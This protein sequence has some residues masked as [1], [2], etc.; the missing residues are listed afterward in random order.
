VLPYLG[1]W[2]ERLVRHTVGPCEVRVVAPVPYCPPLPA[3]PDYTRFRQVPAFR[4]DGDVAVYHPRFLLGPGNW[5]HGLEAWGYYHGVRRLVGRIRREFPFDLIHAHFGY[6]DGVVAAWLGQRY[7]VPVVVTEHAIWRPWLDNFRSVRQKVLQ[8]AARFALHLAVSRAVRDSVAHFTGESEHLRVIPVGVDA[9]V[10]TPPDGGAERDPNQ[11]LFVGR[12]QT[13]KGVDILLRAVARLAGLRPGLQLTIVGGS[14]YPNWR[15]EEER[16]RRLAQELGLGPRVAFVGIQPE[17]QV[18]QLMRRSAVVVLPS[19]RE[20][21]GAVLV[22]ALACGTPVVAT[23]CGGPEDVVTD[24]VGRLVPLE[25]PEALASAIDDV[26]GAAGR[27]DARA[28]RAYAL[29]HFSWERVAGRTVGS[30]QEAC[31]QPARSEQMEV[32]PC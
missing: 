2:V 4:R 5:L 29:Q 3:L 24:A 22:E 7:G 14:F 30:Y 23:R 8:A 19:R 10:F 1:L 9:T 28:L 20:S 27:Y 21:F 18:A 13:I 16:I 11:V 12:I 31:G 25:D 6:P 26:L 17:K 32:V 15:P